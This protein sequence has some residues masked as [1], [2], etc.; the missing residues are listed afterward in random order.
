MEDVHEKFV[1]VLGLASSICCV[2]GPE[3]SH[4]TADSSI[5]TFSGAF[6]LLV[7]PSLVLDLFDPFEIWLSPDLMDVWDADLG[8]FL[9][10]SS[11]SVGEVGWG[12]GVPGRGSR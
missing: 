6:F 12:C 10:G 5:G 7:P 3:R 1:G 2:W 8:T 9:G 11:P 4:N